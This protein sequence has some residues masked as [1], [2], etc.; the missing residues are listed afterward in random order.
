[1]AVAETDMMRPKGSLILKVLIVL[2]LVMLIASVLYPGRLWEEQDNLVQATRDRMENLNY[3]VQRYNQ[4]NNRFT[5]DVQELITFIQQDSIEVRRPVIEFERLSLYDADA[6]SFI[7]G[8]E[9]LF[10]YDSLKVE[11]L[12]EDTLRMTI[13]PRE[14]YNDLIPECGFIVSC[15]RGISFEYRDRGDN[16]IYVY[17]YAPGEIH[18]AQYPEEF[19]EVRVPSHRYL[20]FMDVDEITSD[21]I[22]N[23]PFT[24][25]LNAQIDIEG[26]LEFTLLRRGEPDPPVLSNE[27]ATNLLMNSLARG[28]RSKLTEFLTE[29]GDSSLYEQQL[30]LANDFYDEEI[31]TYNSSR[32][33]KT[34]DANTQLSIPVDSVSFYDNETIIRN[35]LFHV[36]TDQQL[37]QWQ[38]LEKTQ[39]ALARTT[40]TESYQMVSVDTVGVTISTAREGRYEVPPATFLDKLFKVGPVENPGY[41]R[42]N[43]LSWEEAR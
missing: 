28:A 10:H 12:H 4:V 16:D 18:R 42:N 34:L 17:I 19:P 39:E 2:L 26:E 32:R 40:Y 23:E 14:R 13:I 21:A 41:I 30:E 1:M 15:P 27:L 20:L 3:V 31:N 22:L 38:G 8:F 11:R 5:A 33:P 9:D 35:Q 25:N 36:V 37:R 7:V 29:A 24:L 6:D 43:D